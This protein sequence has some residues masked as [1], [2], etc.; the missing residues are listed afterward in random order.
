MSRNSRS[1]GFKASTKTGQRLKVSSNR[2]REAGIEPATP[3]YTFFVACLGINQ[4]RRVGLRFVCWFCYGNTQRLTKSGFMEKP[5]IEPA[6]LGLQGI[7]LIHYTF[8]VAF[9]GINQFRRDWVKI[10]VGILYG[11]TQRLTEN[12]FYREAG[13]RTCDLWFTRHSAYPLHLFC[14]VP[15]F[16][17]VPPGWFKICVGFVSGTPKGSPKVV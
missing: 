13:N 10:C 7:A 8:F 5:G 14:G 15:G 16:K 4:F 1:S 9:L 11:N 17:P 6:T 12:C 2:L 3:G